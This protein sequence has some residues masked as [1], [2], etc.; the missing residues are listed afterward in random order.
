MRS[1]DRYNQLPPSATSVPHLSLEQADYRGQSLC[2]PLSRRMT[3][4]SSSGVIVLPSVGQQ[5]EKRDPTHRDYLAC[6]I[7]ASG[8]L[9]SHPACGTMRPIPDPLPIGE[10][11]P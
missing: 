10:G 8:G 11:G 6:I 7:A 4:A 1:I 9:T 2:A 5:C 3:A